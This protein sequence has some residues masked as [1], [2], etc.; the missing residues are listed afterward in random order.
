MI[1][2]STQ[3]FIN[4]FMDMVTD[5]NILIDWAPNYLP[6]MGE[7]LEVRT[8]EEQQKMLLKQQS[9]QDTLDR[10]AD[11]MTRAQKKYVDKHGPDTP[12]PDNI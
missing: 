10:L 12:R 9:P 4:P 8:T 1:R 6:E 5:P 2:C 7:F 11:F 3:G